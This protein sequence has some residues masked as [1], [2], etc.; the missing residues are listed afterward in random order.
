MVNSDD[1]EHAMTYKLDIDS[2]K[3]NITILLDEFPE[4]ATGLITEEEK[5]G[6]VIGL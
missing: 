6:I 1:P 4:S 3:K 2:D 5:E